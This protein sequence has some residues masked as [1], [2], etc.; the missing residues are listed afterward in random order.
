MKWIISELFYPDEVSTALIMTD[1]TEKIA[2][3]EP[4][5]VICGP[6]GYEKSYKSRDKKLVGDITVHRVKIPNLNKNRLLLRVIRLF[7][8][9]VKMTWVILKKVKKGDTILIV[10]NPV[11]LLLCVA[12]LKPFK[13]AKIYIL[14]HDVFPDN[15]VPAGLIRA[16]G[17]KFRLI[18]KIFTTAY[19]KADKLIALGEDMQILLANKLD[20]DKSTIQIIPNWSDPSVFPIE[21]YSASTYF[22]LDLSN[23]I[24]IVFAGNIGR[25]Q[26]IQQFIT[27][28]IKA[29]NPHLALILV[30]DGAIKNEISKSGNHDNVYFVGSRPRSQQI[31]FLNAA[32]IGLVTLKE[33]MRGLGVPSK[34]YN[35]MAA[36][37]PLLFLGDKDSETDR[38]IN[39][40]NNGWSFQWQEEEAL[41]WFLQ[42]LSMDKLQL[43]RKKGLNSLK[44]ANL[45]FRKEIILE[46]YKKLL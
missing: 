30:G 21:N 16:S 34:V 2:E 18:D 14:F 31:Y 15:L 24:I 26:G 4:V 43:V 6:S 19:K 29:A 17:W 37:K 27:L 25:V 11:F 41:I 1:I 3:S 36:K 7:L 42:N 12:F 20:V 39:K 44:A 45:N 38:Y 46:L 23:K 33:G 8:L 9:T 32:D 40:F 22:D 28:F 10:T 35:I 13:K 5:S